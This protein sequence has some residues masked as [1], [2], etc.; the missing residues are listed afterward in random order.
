MFNAL[1]ICLESIIVVK[2]SCSTQSAFHWNHPDYQASI[3]WRSLSRNAQISEVSS[4]TVNEARG[5][6]I[7]LAPVHGL[8]RSMHTHVL[9][10]KRFH[11]YSRAG[12]T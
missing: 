2:C 7:D 5:K 1:F 10:P 8:S 12:K 9:D 4:R 11:V 6:G 3:D